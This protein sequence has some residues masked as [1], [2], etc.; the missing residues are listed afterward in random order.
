M[1]AE[2]DLNLVLD[3][4]RHV[5]HRKGYPPLDF[6]GKC[7]QWALLEALVQRYD[8]YFPTDQLVAAVWHDRREIS[9]GNDSFY[10]TMS[11]LRKELKILG[12]DPKHTKGLGYRLKKL[13]HG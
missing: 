8:A 5:A 10:S 1:K 12:L 7:I 6:G 3:R 4:D 2:N 9:I 13:D 11:L